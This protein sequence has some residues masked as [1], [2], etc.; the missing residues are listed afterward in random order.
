MAERFGKRHA[1]VLEAIKEIKNGVEEKSVDLFIPSKYQHPQNKQWYPEYL[2]TRDGFTLLAMG[3]TG[4]E[5]DESKAA[6]EELH[7]ED[8]TTTL[9]QGTGSN[10]KSMLM[11]KIS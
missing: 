5:A 4:K 3:F 10:Y 11:K 7:D 1:D 2:M 6:K 9:I 8:K